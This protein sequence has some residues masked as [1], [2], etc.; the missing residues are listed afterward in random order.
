MTAQSRFP[1]FPPV[2]TVRDQAVVEVLAPRYAVYAA[3]VRSTI[4]GAA[5]YD[6]AVTADLLT[7]ISATIARQR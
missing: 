6:E 5:D 1:D 4:D 3:A 7:Q 2:E